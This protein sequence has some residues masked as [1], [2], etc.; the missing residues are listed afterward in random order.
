MSDDQPEQVP[1]TYVPG[2]TGPMLADTRTPKPSDSPGQLDQPPPQD[3][4]PLAVEESTEEVQGNYESA[5]RGTKQVT[6][7]L[8]GVEYRC[9]DQINP[10]AL[11]DW[12]IMLAEVAGVTGK[13]EKQIRQDP[14]A[15]LKVTKLTKELALMIEW[16][17]H[18][19]E[20]PEVKRRLYDK[21][22]GMDLGELSGALGTV[23]SQY[24]GVSTT[25]R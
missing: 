11:A 14:D 22:G 1:T 4:L 23:I 15:L 5:V 18:D 9:V 10:L 13:T 3:A 20:W 7:T 16:V 12:Q 21:N 25:K 2:S 8:G 17:I 19:D 24:S 6:I